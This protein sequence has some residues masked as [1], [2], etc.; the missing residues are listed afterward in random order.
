MSWNYQGFKNIF[1]YKSTSDIY[2]FYSGNKCINNRFLI[3]FKRYLLKR[4][5]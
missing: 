1:L 5:N 3:T 2:I 4:F